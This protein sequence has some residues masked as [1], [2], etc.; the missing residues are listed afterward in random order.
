MKTLGIEAQ[1]L[2]NKMTG[3]EFSIDVWDNGEYGK[4]DVKRGRKNKKM[5]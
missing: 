1:V 3:E 2:T 5:K 4:I